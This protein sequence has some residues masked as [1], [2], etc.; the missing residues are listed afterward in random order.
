[1]RVKRVLWN[2]NIIL[3]VEYTIVYVNNNTRQQKQKTAQTYANEK[4]KQKK[5][6]IFA[7]VIIINSEKSSSSNPNLV[8][9]VY[10]EWLTKPL[11]MSNAYTYFAKKQLRRILDIH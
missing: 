5:I 7:I 3:C 11:R 1:M 10:V 4:Y 6:Y 2:L 9:D 8:S